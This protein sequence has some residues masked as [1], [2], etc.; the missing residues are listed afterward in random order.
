MDTGR[1]LSE[2][3]AINR[4]LSYCRIRTVPSKTVLIHAGDVPD[5]LYYV[6]KGSVEVL[7][8]DE[9]GNEMVLAYL[10]KGQFFGE[11]GLFNEQPARSA[12]VRTRSQCELA[13]MT[14]PRFRQIAAESP[15]LLFELAT[16][17]ASRLD[18]TNRKL[19]DLAFVDVTGRVAH[20][21]MDLCNEPDAMTHPEGTQI[22]VSRQELS[23]L[24]GC[25]REMAGRVLKVLEE[26]GLLTARGK[27]MVVYGV[28]PRL[29]GK[30]A[31]MAGPGGAAAGLAALRTSRATTVP[32]DDEDED[33]ED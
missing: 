31:A 24:V 21:I 5:V 18:R 12:W 26:Q 15:T 16:Q 27:T 20:A 14:Y 1:P 19:G 13:E 2:I 25:S 4:F 8:E 11:M 6:V 9:E 28:R 32:D 23:R 17:L 10:N 7:I 29:K 30:A 22:K 3:P 33:D